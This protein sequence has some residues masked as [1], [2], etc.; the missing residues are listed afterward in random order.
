MNKKNWNPTFRS[1]FERHEAELR[2]LFLSLY[3]DDSKSLDAFA[4]MLRQAYAG[5]SAALRALDEERLASPGWFRGDGLTGMLLDAAAFAGTLQGVREKLDYLLDCGVGCLHL[6]P[7]LAGSGGQ[8][9]AVTDFRSVEPEL[10][11][12]EDLAALA[13]D[14][15]AHGLSLSLDLV[16]N[17]TGDSHAWALSAK[18]GNP[19]A[20][21]RYFF[22]DNWNV[23]RQFEQTLPQVFPS[24]APGSF[25]WCLEADK[26]VMT[27]FYPSQWDLN[28]ANPVV[29][30]D[31]AENLL[32][33]CNRGAD[34]IRL[35][36]LPFLWKA[37]GTSCRDLPQ[38]HMLLRVL[39]I[40][41][42]IVCPGTLLI[43][44]LEASPAAA[45]PY[46]GSAERPECH[47][48]R[49]PSDTAA[50]WHTVATKDVRLLQHQLGR[51]FALP[52]AGAFVNLLR[53]HEPTGWDLDYAFLR[54]FGTDEA[55]HRQYLASYLS[56]DWY[57]S[58]SRG[59]LIG[60]PSDRGGTRLCGTAASLCGVEAALM[61]HNPNK[62]DRAL[63]LDVT[64]HACLF[65]LS[66]VP[67][68]C[69]GDEIGQ[70][71]DYPYHSDPAKAGDGRFL[72][73]GDMD[74]RAAVQ[75][76]APGSVPGRIFPALRQLT[77]LRRSHP[78]FGAGAEAWLLL[79]EDDSVLGI[80]RR[81][82]GETLAAF[83]NFSDAERRVPLHLPGAFT[84]LLTGEAAGREGV[85]LPPGGFVW[86]LN[87]GDA[88][89]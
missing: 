16:L 47:L 71:N 8:G 36:A 77:E 64:L 80:A 17:H 89:N 55:S 60:S 59:E 84:N 29:L 21:A 35:R 19:A 11:T 27:T 38:V 41:C 13:E 75:R 81:C 42:E 37:L 52:C 24:T 31:M 44:D 6:A 53:G 69:G 12:M 22:Y 28:Y 62:L 82:P 58:S 4:R 5:R 61:E 15:H 86:L 56:G 54:R 18:A 34:M 65:T 45:L 68:L 14:C 51:R 20:Q 7:L 73:R 30:R 85:L 32:F 66:G 87:A 88:E 83:F 67:V 72:H 57:D 23:P 39:R 50:V 1:R 40:S 2:E 9:C 33:L 10:G 26:V 78:V 48:L 46:L 3:P 63:R 25:S 49:S 76:S 74:W 70:L 43:G 79:T